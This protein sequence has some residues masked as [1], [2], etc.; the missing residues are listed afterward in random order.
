MNS[1]DSLAPLPERIGRLAELA[2]D[3]WWSWHAEA[4]RVFRRR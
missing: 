4:R 1:D 3:L 2:A